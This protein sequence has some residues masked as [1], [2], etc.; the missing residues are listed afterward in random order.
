MLFGTIDEALRASHGKT[1]A[2]VAPQN[3]RSY[4]Q[5]YHEIR[6]DFL[7]MV[8]Q[9]DLDVAPEEQAGLSPFSAEV[10]QMAQAGLHVENARSSLWLNWISPACLA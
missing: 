3:A 6:T 4:A 9:F 2:Y 10:D 8:G 5:T 1:G 7:E